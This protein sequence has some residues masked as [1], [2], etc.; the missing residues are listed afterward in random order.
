MKPAENQLLKWRRDVVCPSCRYN[1]HGLPGAIVTCPECGAECDVLA[2]LT[3][4]W[5]GPW[6]QAPGFSNLLTP[7]VWWYC[8]GIVTLVAWLAGAVAG[9]VVTP[10]TITIWLL[11]LWRCCSVFPGTRG[12]WLS[13]LVHVMLAGCLATIFWPIRLAGDALDDARTAVAGLW[14]LLSPVAAFAMWV[15]CRKGQK[16]IAGICIRHYLD[17]TRRL[18]PTENGHDQSDSNG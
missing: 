16:W 11:H 14:L 3:R 15:V 9:A 17:G 12:V 13:L 1:L 18:P 4:S 5:F 7:V 2:M 8:L 10:L 6:H